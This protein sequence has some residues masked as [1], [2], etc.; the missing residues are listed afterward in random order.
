MSKINKKNKIEKEIYKK[1]LTAIKKSIIIKKKKKEKKKIKNIKEYKIKYQNLSSFTAIC[2]VKEKTSRGYILEIIE[3]TNN[4][5]Y[6]IYN[7]LEFITFNNSYEIKDIIKYE[8]NGPK[9][10]KSKLIKKYINKKP[11]T[12]KEKIKKIPK[13]LYK[14]KN[15]TVDTP[16]FQKEKKKKK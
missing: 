15:P 1:P 10:I 3:P 6:K 4:N 16:K 7:L 9:N 13:I 12:P 14:Q 5:N 8:F 2:E 11:Q